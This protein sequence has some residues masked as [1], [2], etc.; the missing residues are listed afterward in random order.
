[1]TNFDALKQIYEALGGDEEITGTN[2]DALKAIA[3]VA[4]SGGGGG[5]VVHA[6]E[7]S[8]TYTLDKTWKEIY[9]AF[10]AGKAVV[11]LQPP[12]AQGDPDLAFQVVSCYYDGHYLASAMDQLGGEVVRIDFTSET[13]S[14][15]PKFIA[16]GD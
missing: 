11:L 8:G 2:L 5:L 16:G 1:M 15:Y 13:A 3:E 12:Q 7:N 10:S 4:G 6:T 14:G 9:D